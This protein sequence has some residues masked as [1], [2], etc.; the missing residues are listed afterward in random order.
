MNSG[1][2]FLSG[3]LH[4]GRKLHSKF[5]ISSFTSLDLGWYVPSTSI[6]PLQGMISEKYFLSGYIHRNGNL[7]SKFYISSFSSFSSF[8][9]TFNPH[10]N[11][12]GDYF[13]QSFLCGYIHHNS[14]LHFKFHVSSFSSFGSALIYHSPFY[15]FKGWFLNI[16]YWLYTS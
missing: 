2:S 6:S 5:H 3:Y 11:H 7:H 14:N 13:W 8:V 4:R 16:F 9:F 10:F 1:K 12:L 15:P